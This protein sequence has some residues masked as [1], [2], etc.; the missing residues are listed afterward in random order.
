M[1]TLD[2]GTNPLIAATVHTREDLPLL[3]ELSGKGII[4]AV[5]FRADGF[6]RGDA[7]ELESILDR[8]KSA[9]LP[10]ILTFRN[11]GIDE[12]QRL[13]MI[14][15]LL[16]GADAVDIELHSDITDEVAGLGREHSKKVI[17]SEHDFEKT[18]PMKQLEIIFGACLEKG[19]DIAKIS[20]M[21]VSPADAAA[22][23]CFCLTASARH[24][25]ICVSM[26]KT[27]RFTRFY[28]PFFGSCLSYGCISR[29]AAP[30]MAGVRELKAELGKYEWVKAP[31]R[32]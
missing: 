24:P 31:G 18:P 1:K 6:Y 15:S 28:A 23:M 8:I 21:P 13:S 25:V 30:G 10:V 3:P 19:A 9:G 7:R 11:R 5:E 22:L 17:I 27:G 32:S 20:V 14:S 29:P 2:T 12:A 16:P 26:G 4:D